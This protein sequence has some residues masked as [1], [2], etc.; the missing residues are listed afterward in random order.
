[1]NNDQM[2]SAA[3]ASTMAKTVSNGPP[4]SWK[5]IRMTA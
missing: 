3:A 2:R 5:Q 1:L 4:N